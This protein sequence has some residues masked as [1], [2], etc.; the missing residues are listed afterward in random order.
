MSVRDNIREGSYEWLTAILLSWWIPFQLFGE[1]KVSYFV[2]L[3]LWAFPVALLLP[4]FLRD[5]HRGSRRRQAIAA[6]VIYVIFAG[7]LLDLWFGATILQFLQC[8]PGATYV[9]CVRGRGGDIPLEEILFYILGGLAVVLVYTWCDLHW[10]SLYN[11]R[12]RRALIPEPGHLI[13]ISPRVALVAVAALAVG[14]GWKFTYD[15]AKGLIHNSWPEWFPEYYTFLVVFA[16]LPLILVYRAVKDFVNWR[17]FSFTGLYVL[18]TASVWEVTL[19]LPNRWW[20]YQED[21]MIGKFVEAWGRVVWIGVVFVGI[22]LYEGAETYYYDPRPPLVKLFTGKYPAP[23]RDP[24]PVGLSVIIRASAD[25]LS[26]TQSLRGLAERGN[27]AGVRPF[28][29]IVAGAVP[30]GPSPD[31]MQSITLSSGALGQWREAGAARS[32]FPALC[33]ID[34]R[35][36]AMPSVFKSIVEILESPRIVG[37]STTCEAYGSKFKQVIA[38]VVRLPVAWITGYDRGLVFC[39]ASDFWQLSAEHRCAIDQKELLRA[40]RELGRRTRRLLTRL[41]VAE[42]LELPAPL[43]MFRK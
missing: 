30:P 22:F 29:V 5:T 32:Q 10:L 39:R 19:G 20:F 14:V 24:V 43:D 36:I 18:L 40:L 4:R 27:L 1:F 31:W 17:A 11:V 2:S 34:E 25:V 6:A 23:D 35:L 15:R 21:A 3:I 41:P 9:K 16:F 26:R 8:P 42:V 13:E 38:A 37:G 12:K 28:E 7:G 33:F